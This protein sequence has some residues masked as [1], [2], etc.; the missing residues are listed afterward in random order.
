M[1]DQASWAAFLV[2]FWILPF[3]IFV[4]CESL[5]QNLINFL[6]IRGTL[7]SPFYYKYHRY[8]EVIIIFKALHQYYLWTCS[9]KLKPKHRLSHPVWISF[10]AIFSVLLLNSA[11]I[12]RF[13]ILA[14]TT[15]CTSLTSWFSLKSPVK[16]CMC[17]SVLIYN[18]G[19]D[20]RRKWKF[21]G[22]SL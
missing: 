15:N 10:T 17:P 8:E 3:F 12:F 11:R 6:L 4:W 22:F 19:G 13:I 14:I 18:F 5:C 2:H 20:E 16:R 21:C 1:V 7:S 9:R